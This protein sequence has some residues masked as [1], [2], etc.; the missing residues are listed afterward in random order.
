LDWIVKLA[1][2]P[3]VARVSPAPDTTLALAQTTAGWRR[4]PEGG[5]LGRSRRWKSRVE[6]MRPYCVSV[7]ATPVV[8]LCQ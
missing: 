1:A 5:P 6:G 4:W 7:A 2:A 8:V 3:A